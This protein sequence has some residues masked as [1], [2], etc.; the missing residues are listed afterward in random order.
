MSCSSSG[1]SETFMTD[2]PDDRKA[3]N[4]CQYFDIGCARIGFRRFD[5]RAEPAEPAEP[6]E[7]AEPLEPAE[8]VEPAYGRCSTINFVTNSG[9]SA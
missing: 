2:S 8:P 5:A 9:D 6:G 1:V 7:P 4:G 3:V